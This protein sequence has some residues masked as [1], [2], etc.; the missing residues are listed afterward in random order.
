MNPLDSSK[1]LRGSESLGLNVSPIRNTSETSSV[2]TTP[3]Q[4]MTAT[5]KL[6]PEIKDGEVSLKDLPKFEVPS[7]TSSG[8][9]SDYLFKLAAEG[10]ELLLEIFKDMKRLPS[11]KKK[12]SAPPSQYSHFCVLCFQLGRPL[13]D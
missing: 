13:S 8:T 7:S 4:M 6:F 5:P 3:Q 10:L 1:K 12:S 11:R 2:T 9:Y